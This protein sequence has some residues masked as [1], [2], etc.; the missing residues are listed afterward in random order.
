MIKTQGDKK[1]ILSK[2]K[3]NLRI[4]LDLDGVCCFWEKSAAKTL[5]IDLEDKKI[6]EQV[7]NGKR[8]E[9]FV[10][11]DEVMWP[12]IDKEGPE[13]WENLEKLPWADDLIELAKSSG[14][15]FCFLTSPSNNPDCA[16]GKIKWIKKHLGDDFKNFLIGKQKHMCASPNS[17]LIDDDKKKCKKFE[18]YGG[19]SFLWPH[20]LKLIDKDINIDE[21]INDLRSLIDYVQN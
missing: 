7:K 18:D 1:I 3:T 21:V 5:G 8:L 6:R 19:H 2:A 15:D 13:W 16:S 14:K 17:I 12:K 4:F 10:G 11:G 9:S 20:S